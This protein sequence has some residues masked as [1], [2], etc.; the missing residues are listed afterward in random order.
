[1]CVFVYDVCSTSSESI[2][3]VSLGEM[4]TFSELLYMFTTFSWLSEDDGKLGNVF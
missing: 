2:R 1:M 4:V 3:R